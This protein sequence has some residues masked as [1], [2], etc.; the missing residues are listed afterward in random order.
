MWWKLKQSES[1]M[2]VSHPSCSVTHPMTTT[3]E[4]R[5]P[6]TRSSLCRC[7]CCAS[8][9]RTMSF[10]PIMPFRWR[11]WSR[12]PMWPCSSPVTAATLASW[13]VCGH[14]RAPTWTESFASSPVPCLRTAAVW[15]ISTDLLFPFP[16]QPWAKNPYTF[17]K[18]S[19]Q[20]HLWARI[21]YF[22]FFSLFIYLFLYFSSFK[23]ISF[24][25]I[26]GREILLRNS[27]TFHPLIRPSFDAL[28][29]F[30]IAFLCMTRLIKYF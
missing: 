4:T 19:A 28:I 10:P 22:Y 15:M 6:F 24:T 2:N 16:L 27:R 18:W 11:R 3:I 5:A 25:C 30:L 17:P 7:Q 12:T 8:T 13:R 26:H 23:H 14:G 9:Q 21:V 1:L 20:V 29:C